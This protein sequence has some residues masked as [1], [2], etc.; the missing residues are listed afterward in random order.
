[1]FQS[2]LPVL[3]KKTKKQRENMLTVQQFSTEDI[4]LENSTT[5]LQ[6]GRVQRSLGY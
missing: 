4:F 1:M 5:Y 3:K 2:V 6:A